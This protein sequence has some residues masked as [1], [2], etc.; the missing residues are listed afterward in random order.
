MKLT[1]GSGIDRYIQSIEKLTLTA[2]PEIKQAVFV[3]GGIVADAVRRSIQDLPARSGKYKDPPVSGVT[4][5]QREG[6]LEGLGISRMKNDGGFI[7]VHIG[8]DGYNSTVTDRWPK[9]VPNAL[10]A[11]SVES[12][13]SWLK[14]HPFVAPAVRSVKTA[15]EMAMAA[16]FDEVIKKDFGG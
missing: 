11:R 6:L 2:E 8:F 13:T 14:K 7:N 15:A 16:K 5:S 12:G 3:G 9:G 1:V 10:V 4:K